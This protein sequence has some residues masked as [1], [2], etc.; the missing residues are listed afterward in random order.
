MSAQNKR[1]SMTLY[2]NGNDPFCHRIKMILAEKDISADIID[3]V[4]EDKLEELYELNPYGGVPTLMTKDLIVYE[5]N[6]IFEYLEERFPYPPL[7]SVFPLERAQARMLCK[8]IDSEWMPYLVNALNADNEDIRQANK[9]ALLKALFSL[10][11]TL[12][13]QSYLLGDDFTIADCSLAVILYNL[14]KLDIRLPEKAMPLI[15]Y[16][17]RLFARNSFRKSIRT[18]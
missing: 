17:K 14:P 9:I 3:V 1:S 12:S 18:Q 7:L 16:A 8:K 10:I 6:I 11:P 5:P 4:A 13:R 15:K 2:T